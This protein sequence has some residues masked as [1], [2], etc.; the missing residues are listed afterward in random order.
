MNLFYERLSQ[1]FLFVVFVFFGVL[2]TAVVG[3]LISL[4]I[5][6]LLKYD[7]QMT[8]YLW[9]VLIVVGGFVL[10]WVLRFFYWLFI[11]P[12]LKSRGAKR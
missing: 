5:L 1:V 8:Y 6:A 7:P 4:P 11:E 10:Y 12:Y 3:F 2:I 9:F